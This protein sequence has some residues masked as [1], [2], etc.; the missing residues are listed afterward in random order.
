MDK[1]EPGATL[2][3]VCSDVAAAQ[4]E[5][6]VSKQDKAMDIAK[7]LAGPEACEKVFP[8]YEDN[9]KRAMELLQIYKDHAA[10]GKLSEDVPFW[11]PST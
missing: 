10:G 11:S 3:A 6:I 7:K 9:K 4:L 5:C 2:P 8:R 1:D